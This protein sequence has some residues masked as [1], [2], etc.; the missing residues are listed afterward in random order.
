M[1]GWNNGRMGKE[2][3]RRQESV[4]RRIASGILE[5]PEGRDQNL[6]ASEPRNSKITG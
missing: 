4:D 1:E 5:E 6:R 3:D 2:E